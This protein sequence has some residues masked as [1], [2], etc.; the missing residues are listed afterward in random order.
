MNLNKISIAIDGPAGAG[1]STVAKIVAEKMSYIYVDTG[2]MYR[3]LTYKA[4]EENI[5]IQNDQALADLLSNTAIELSPSKTGQLVIVDGKDI[6]N[7]IRED[8]VTNTVSTVA[9]HRLVREKMVKQQKALGQAGGVVMDGRDIGTEVLPNAE[10]K[11][12]LVASVEVRAERRHLE[13]IEKGY[14]SD[15]EKLKKEIS[16]RDQQDSERE[17]S[18]L[19]KAEDAIEIDTSFLSISE[20]A[21]QIY[22]LA[23][24]RMGD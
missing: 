6:T 20:V 9:A 3:A 8:A 1:K 12:F 11:V 17:V 14:A 21:D 2:A 23:N 24:E 10:L 15:L 18:P 4:L 5:N 13:N 19:R 16:L 22:Q 7:I